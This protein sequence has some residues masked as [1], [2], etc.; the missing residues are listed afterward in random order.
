[1]QKTS[2]KTPLLSFFRSPFMFSVD[3][4]Y[5]QR[6]LL[7]ELAASKEYAFEKNEKKKLR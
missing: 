4:S 7:L 1:M 6:L 5:I 3:F 2:K